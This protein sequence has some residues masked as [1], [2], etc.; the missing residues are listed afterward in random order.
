MA[1]RLACDSPGVLALL[2]DP[3]APGPDNCPLVPTTTGA[4]RVC[5]SGLP[6]RSQISVS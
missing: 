5:S 4:Y 2:L 3:L 6:V 1:G